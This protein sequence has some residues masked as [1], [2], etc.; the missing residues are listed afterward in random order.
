[1]SLEIEGKVIK[2]LPEQ[3]GEGRNGTW[4]KQ[5]FVIETFGEYPK[6]VCFSTWGDR[7]DTVK[8]LALG[9]VVKVSFRPESREYNE[10]WY[11]DLIAWRIEQ[12]GGQTNQP[13]NTATQTPPPPPPPPDDMQEEE[14]DDLPF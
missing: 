8:T 3:T 13:T 7:T 14:G 10:R 6:S 5:D 9:Q 4:K 1:M 2:I 11:T 12:T